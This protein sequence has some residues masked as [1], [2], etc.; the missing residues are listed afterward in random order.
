MLGVKVKGFHAQR[1]LT[2][3]HLHRLVQ[4]F[5]KQRGAEDVV[6][7]ESTVVT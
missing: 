3:D 2:P 1:S 5:P 4:S 6:A 7:L